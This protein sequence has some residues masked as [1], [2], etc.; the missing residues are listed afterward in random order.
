MLWWVLKMFHFSYC[1]N[2]ADL[3]AQAFCRCCR[4]GIDTVNG[5]I[6]L[7]CH[8]RHIDISVLH[9][10]H[11]SEVGLRFRGSQTAWRILRCR[12]SS[13][14][15]SLQCSLSRSGQPSHSLRQGMSGGKSAEG[16]RWHRRIPSVRRLS[17]QR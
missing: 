6:A 8:H 11:L 9:I 4:S 10:R 14:P 7:R 1:R 13:L 5:R 2:G 15:Y 3:D 12:N 17:R 16:C